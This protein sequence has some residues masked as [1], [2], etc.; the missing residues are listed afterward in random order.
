MAADENRGY[1]FYRERLKSPKFILAP[2]VDASE[3]PFRELC[4]ECSSSK[5]NSLLISTIIIVNWVAW[6]TK[7]A[8]PTLSTQGKHGTQLAYTPMIAVRPFVESAKIRN[9]YLYHSNYDR[10]LIAQFCANDVELFLKA[11][12]LAKD[13]CDA[14]DI[15]L[16]S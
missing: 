16:G 8:N 6:L 10:P 3:F 4:R 11:I 7:L 15:N 14:I 9:D 12:E 5:F 1:K 2:M 13:Y